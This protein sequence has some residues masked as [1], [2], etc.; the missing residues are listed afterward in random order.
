[1]KKLNLIEEEIDFYLDLYLGEILKECECDASDYNEVV[2]GEEPEEVPETLDDIEDDLGGKLLYFGDIEDDDDNELFEV[3]E[4]YELTEDNEVNEGPIGDFVDS[5]KY[6][7]SPSLRK[8]AKE[9]ANKRILKGAQ[10]V[11]RQ[12]AALR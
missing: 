7:L 11:G 8:A 12:I 5:L 10:R 1:M 6:S 3:N 9:A 2:T 4:D